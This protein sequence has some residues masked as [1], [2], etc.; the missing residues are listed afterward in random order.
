MERHPAYRGTLCRAVVEL[1]RKDPAAGQDLLGGDLVDAVETIDACRSLTWIPAHIL[2]SINGAYHD[3]VGDDRFVDFWRRYSVSAADAPL[4]GPLFEG[5]LR[6]FGRDPGGLFGWVGRAWQVTTRDYGFF[7][8]RRGGAEAILTMRD[9]PKQCPL[10]RIALSTQGSLMGLLDL[11]G[12]AGEVV[13]DTSRLKHRGVAR[14]HVTWDAAV[15][16]G[17][18]TG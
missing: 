5:A 2:D 8:C 6:I 18:K 14:F 17:P 1:L 12:C 4:F 3:Q 9:L 13:V 15:K 11:A 7:D 10:E 16:A